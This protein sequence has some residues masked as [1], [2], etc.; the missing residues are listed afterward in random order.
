MVTPTTAAVAA[1]DA[2]TATNAATTI[3]AALAIMAT[4]SAANI[5]AAA[6]QVLLRPFLLSQIL[7]LPRQVLLLRLPLLHTSHALPCHNVYPLP[8]FNPAYGR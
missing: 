5:R 6:V 7:L 3:P 1:T 8:S 4:C 2:A